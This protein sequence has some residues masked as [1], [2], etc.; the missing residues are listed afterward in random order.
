MNG[1]A[2][3]RLLLIVI[4]LALVGLF[5]RVYY[6][7]DEPR[8]GSMVVAMAHQ[9]DRALPQLAGKPFAEKPPLLY[10]LDGC[11]SS[12]RRQLLIRR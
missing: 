8:E 5:G 9:T 6:T 2:I 10:W 3:S 7:P 4:P 12:R 11:R 1:Q